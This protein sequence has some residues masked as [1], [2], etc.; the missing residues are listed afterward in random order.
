[1]AITAE[2][3]HE[4]HELLKKYVDRYDSINRA[5]ESLNNVSGSTI[6]TIFRGGEYPNISE[7]MWRSIYKQVSGEEQ[8]GTVLI[9]TTA[10]KDILFCM[11]VV[12]KTKGFTWII[13]PAGS[14][15]SVSSEIMK[16]RKNVFYVLCDED[17]AKSDFAQEMARAVGLRVNTQKKARAIILDV[18]QEISEL[19]DV[20]F[21]FDEGDKLNDKIIHYFITIYNHLKGKAG[22]VFCST[23]YMEKRMKNGLKF[24]KRGFQELWSRIGRKFY[25]AEKN[26]PYDVEN[27]CRANAVTSR[28]DIDVVVKETIAAD[29]DLRRADIK[30]KAINLSKLSA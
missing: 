19:E 18:V 17:M 26:T 14:G 2:Y 12:Q 25:H 1:M 4:V 8:N 3:K 11:E 24:N 22:V 27:L 23:D 7:A 16:S 30:I 20:L 15:K 13:S 29:M 9:E 21:I 28:R 6:R 10:S 5:A